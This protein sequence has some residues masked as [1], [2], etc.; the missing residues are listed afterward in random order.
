MIPATAREIANRRFILED[1]TPMPHKEGM[2]LAPH[3]KGR[4][5]AS[6]PAGQVTQQPLFYACRHYDRETRLCTDFE[7]RPPLCRDFPRY[8]LPLVKPTSALPY[9]CSFNADVPVELRNRP[10]AGWQP[11]LLEGATFE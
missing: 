8:G 4:E 3:L 9:E 10:P 2:R 5:L 11:D 6:T 7:N 1:L